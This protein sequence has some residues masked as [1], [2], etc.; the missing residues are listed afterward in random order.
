MPISL[1]QP[2]RDVPLAFVDVETTGASAEYGDRVIEIGIV[3][4]E[5]GKVVSEMQELIDPQRR[6]SPGIVALTGISTDMVVGKPIFAQLSSAILE[7][8]RGAVIVGHNVRFDLSFLLHEFRRSQLDL[9]RELGPSVH[10]L[11]TVRIARKLFGRGG[12][13]LQRLALR[14]DLAPPVA[15]RALAD[16]QTT[17]CVFDRMLGFIGGWNTCLCDV[18]KLQGG[19]MG[20]LPLNSRE[21]TL[22]LELEEALD[23]RKPVIMEYLDARLHR[24]KRIIEPVQ[25][26][27]FKGE[28]TLVAFCRLR[29]ANRTFKLDRIVQL[30]RVD[31]VLVLPPECAEGE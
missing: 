6:I 28:M 9:P 22:P 19:P 20:L 16:A 27:R 25:V 12:N 4:V 24:T 18:L 1:I 7:Q 21:P 23:A 3:R 2:M 8:L 10:V 13:G 11:D 30:K 29:Q 14:L 15:H 31:E 26:R 5:G 17:L